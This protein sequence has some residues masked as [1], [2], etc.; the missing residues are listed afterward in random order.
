MVFKIRV[1]F[2]FFKRTIE[3]PKWDS[4]GLVVWK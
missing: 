2:F 4:A 1:V 3:I